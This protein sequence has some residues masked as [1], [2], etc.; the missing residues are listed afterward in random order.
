MDPDRLIE[1][2]HWSWFVV[3]VADQGLEHEAAI[4]YLLGQKITLLLDCSLHTLNIET[5]VDRAGEICFV[6]GRLIKLYASPQGD[7][8]GIMN[9]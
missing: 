2:L 9:S 1:V 7:E 3:G 4:W 6:A 5:L 8:E